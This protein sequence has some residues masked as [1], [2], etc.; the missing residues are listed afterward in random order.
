MNDHMWV[1]CGELELLCKK[2]TRFSKSNLLLIS[3]I[4]SANAKLLTLLL[5]QVL[6]DWMIK[7]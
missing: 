3:Q 4:F 6:V 5:T 7:V 1:Y 2:Y